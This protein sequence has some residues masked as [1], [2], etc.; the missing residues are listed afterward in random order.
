MTITV[1][2]SSITFPDATTQTTAGKTGTVTSVATGN[3]LSGG[4]ITTTGTLVVA[5]PSFNTVGSYVLGGSDP[6]SGGPFYPN[7]NYG[8]SSIGVFAGG[9]NG[10]QSGVS[11]TWKAL[12]AS[13]DGNYG[14][15][16]GTLWC[17]VS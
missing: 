8:S 14:L 16:A 7:S 13:S 2:G 11:G 9:D 4:T 12:G 6:P 1:G 5:C 3:G 15:P 10:V 17:R